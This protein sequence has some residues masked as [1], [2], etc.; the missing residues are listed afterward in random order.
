MDYLVK[1]KPMDLRP[2]MLSSTIFG[3][4]SEI[5]IKNK[6]DKFHSFSSTNSPDS[7]YSSDEAERELVNIE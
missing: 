3:F 1:I 2:T 5:D 7:L 6:I 4:D